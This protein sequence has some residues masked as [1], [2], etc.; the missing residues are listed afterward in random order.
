MRKCKGKWRLRWIAWQLQLQLVLVLIVLVVLL[1]LKLAVAA[2]VQAVVVTSA[3]GIVSPVA[4][5]AK[6]V[7]KK[8]TVNG[9]AAV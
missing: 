9:N 2:A 4:L 6:L 1:V 5:T 3:L 7:A 8:K